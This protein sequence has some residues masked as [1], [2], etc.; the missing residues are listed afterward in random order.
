MR[1][2]LKHLFPY[3][4]PHSENETR[5]FEFNVEILASLQAIA[6]SERRSLEEVAESLLAQA[7]QERQKAEALLEPWRNLSP[8]LQEITALICLGYT[9]NEIAERLSISPETVKS[10]VRT[11]L[12]RFGV[13]RKT[14]LR[15]RLADWDFSRL[16]RGQ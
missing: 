12:A 6:K 11:I 15:S 5:G 9:N 2:I 13:R 3:F 10:H 4:N 7:I 1:D 14:E 16:K 8:R